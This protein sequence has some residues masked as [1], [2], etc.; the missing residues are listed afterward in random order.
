MLSPKLTIIVKPP[1]YEANWQ[2]SAR[3]GF[4][5]LWVFNIR[6]NNATELSA[7]FNRSDAQEQMNHYSPAKFHTT[8]EERFYELLD[9]AL[10]KRKI[11][12]RKT[13]CRGRE[14][15]SR[16]AVFTRDNEWWIKEKLIG[17]VLSSRLVHHDLMQ[18]KEPN[19]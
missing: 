4:P 8:I 15:G 14:Y 18:Y 6:V 17:G 2:H 1:W 19:E 12:W 5:Y 3:E 11:E 7:L 13:T 9:E 10:G 16:L